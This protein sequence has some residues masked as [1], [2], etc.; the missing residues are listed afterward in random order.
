M[1]LQS[2]LRPC[3]LYVEY[4]AGFI[5]SPPSLSLFSDLTDIQPD[6]S[7]TARRLLLCLYLRRPGLL[8]SLK[9]SGGRSYLRTPST[10]GSIPDCFELKE[11]GLLIIAK[12]D[13]PIS[14]VSKGSLKT[15][16]LGL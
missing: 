14:L 1:V 7:D 3:L 9:S 16:A 5:A 6:V 13:K 11:V 12:L 15:A 2:H 4:L 8:Y 10:N